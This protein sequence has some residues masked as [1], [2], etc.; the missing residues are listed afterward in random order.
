M[1]F[2]E[3]ILEKTLHLDVNEFDEKWASKYFKKLSKDT[4]YSFKASSYQTKGSTESSNLNITIETNRGTFYAS[5][6][7]KRQGTYFK[8]Q[9]I[10]PKA[11]MLR[12]KNDIDTFTSK[13]VDKIKKQPKMFGIEVE[14]EVK[15]KVKRGTTRLTKKLVT[16]TMKDIKVAGAE[17]SVYK[18]FVSNT[19]SATLK[20][21]G[22][23]RTHDF[24]DIY[25]TTI[26]A[27]WNDD[28][29]V[30]LTS[31]YSGTRVTNI[32]SML[33]L[34]GDNSEIVFDGDKFIK[35]IKKCI[36]NHRKIISTYRKG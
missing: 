18:R 31:D 14:K 6:L 7:G 32:I 16:D 27:K 25:S 36:S 26:N 29:S 33:G 11:T 4:G 5:Y 21:V 34:D 30:T 28:G 17:L 9:P 19:F 2:R 23:G 24:G 13:L 20:T 15:P 3:L 10:D 1:T 35:A 12:F 8:F 22:K